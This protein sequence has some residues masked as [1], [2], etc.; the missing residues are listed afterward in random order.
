LRVGF[1]HL[2]YV[3]V[4]LSFRDFLR[5]KEALALHGRAFLG[6]AGQL[7]YV[8]GLVSSEQGQT[9]ETGGKGGRF[10]F[11]LGRNMGL[12]LGLALLGHCF[13]ELFPGIRVFLGQLRQDCLLLVLNFGG[14]LLGGGVVR[15][16]LAGQEAFLLNNVDVVLHALVLRQRL[17]RILNGFDGLLLFLGRV[18]VAA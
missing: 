10:E 12:V 13:F 5:W 6:N 17:G 8:Q 11:I 7:V 15:V 3:V 16:S 14:R 4:V 2:H 1:D 18:V 9:F